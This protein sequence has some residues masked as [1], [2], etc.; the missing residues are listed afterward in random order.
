MDWKFQVRHCGIRYGLDKIRKVTNKHRL[1]ITRNTETES[2]LVDR[3]KETEENLVH[4]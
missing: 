4:C 1:F 2:D 3:H